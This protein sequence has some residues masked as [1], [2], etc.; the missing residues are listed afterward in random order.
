MYTLGENKNCTTH[1]KYY[2]Y[3]YYYTV[4]YFPYPSPSLLL[5]Y[6]NSLTL[7]L[8]NLVCAG[9]CR[10]ILYTYIILP[11]CNNICSQSKNKKTKHIE[12]Q[13]YNDR[14]LTHTSMVYV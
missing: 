10:K 9:C 14:E 2:Y 5:R 4:D 1:I 8:S 12:F 13:K 11:F 7:R 3:Y 6:Y